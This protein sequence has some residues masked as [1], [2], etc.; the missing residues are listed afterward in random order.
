M[1]NMSRKLNFRSL[2]TMVFLASFAV[3]EAGDQ[4]A[5]VPEGEHIALW[6]AG[7]VP[8]REPHQHNSPFIEWFVPSNRTTDAV[9]VL[10]PG[11]GY[12]ICNWRIG[13]VLTHGFKNWLLSKGMTVVRLHHRTPRPKRVEKHVTAW[14]D[15]QRA[16][17]LVR[18]GAAKHGVNPDKIGF[19]GFSAA[20]HQALLMAVSS[21]TKKYE[22]IDEIDSLPCNINYVVAC[23]P[24]Y[25]LRNPKYPK[26]ND[27][28]KFEGTIPPVFL[29]HGDA[30]HHTP[31]ASIRMYEKLHAMK[32]PVE[33]HILA[34]RGHDLWSKAEPGTPAAEWKEMIWRWLV[35][36]KFCPIK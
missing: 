13:S 24:A 36:M 27:E 18:A 9:L 35:Q 29:I 17:R 32:V 7:R 14:Q 16:V 3:C 33:M 30:D 11:G 25:V 20:A 28:F 2:L 26:P 4:L 10:T 12:G 8:G 23:F 21:E 19:Y 15:A 22:G 5:G 1:R 31:M 6:P 34:T